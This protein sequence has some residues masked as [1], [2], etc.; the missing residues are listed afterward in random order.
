[1]STLLS[2]TCGAIPFYSAPFEL[3]ARAGS[4][5]APRFQ[6]PAVSAL[7]LH[8]T[9]PWSWGSITA[10]QNDRSGWATLLAPRESHE[11]R[12]KGLPCR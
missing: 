2:V 12:T 5:A 7:L 9:Y 1:M 3:F 4:S 10:R 6:L 11:E 8:V